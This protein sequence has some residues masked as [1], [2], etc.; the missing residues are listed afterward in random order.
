MSNMIREEWKE[1]LFQDGIEYTAEGVARVIAN[2]FQYLE[3]KKMRLDITMVTDPAQFAEM[4]QLSS[5]QIEQYINYFENQHYDNESAR[6]IVK[7][8]NVVYHTLDITID[9][10]LD[11][12]EYV[13]ANGLTLTKGMNDKFGVDFNEIN[14]FLVEVME[15]N[16][17]FCAKQVIN[18]GREIIEDI[19]NLL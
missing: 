13:S 7:C 14:L 2:M 3:S 10:A 17:M 5:E 9:E 15:K 16:A 1:Y 6:K 18:Y 19:K 12:A 11:F 8:M 4:N